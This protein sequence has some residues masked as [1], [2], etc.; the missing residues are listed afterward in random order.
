[1]QIFGII[2]LLHEYNDMHPKNIRKCKKNENSCNIG[3]AN[4][5]NDMQLQNIRRAKKVAKKAKIWYHLAPH[6]YNIV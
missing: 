6:E 5:Y 3:G 2:W 4:E 1:M